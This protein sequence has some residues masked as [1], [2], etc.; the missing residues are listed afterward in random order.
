[1]IRRLVRLFRPLDTSAAD[2]AIKEAEQSI[3]AV[4]VR[5]RALRMDLS[6]GDPGE[7]IRR[8]A[9]DVRARSGA[10]LHR[11]FDAISRQP[12]PEDMIERA[13]VAAEALRKL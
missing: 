12:M 9:G 6:C 4:R 10:W 11:Q 8:M 1:M 13:S 3:H 7:V 2:A 5:A